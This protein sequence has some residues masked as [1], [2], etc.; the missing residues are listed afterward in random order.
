MGVH[1]GSIRIGTWVCAHVV[2]DARSPSDTVALDLHFPSVKAERNGH[3]FS[4]PLLM[5]ETWR[6]MVKQEK[7]IDKWQRTGIYMVKESQEHPP[8]HA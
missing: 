2:F 5:T 8:L 1:W 7:L 6:W 4:N 3:I